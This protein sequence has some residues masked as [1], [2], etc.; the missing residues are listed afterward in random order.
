MQELFI[1]LLKSS[2]LI[3]AFFLS[4][5]FLLRKETFFTSNR[6]FL[7]VGL[8]TSVALP[9]FFIRKIIFVEKPKISIEDLVALSNQSNATSAIQQNVAQPIDWLQMFTTVYILIVLFLF[10]KIIVN[11]ISLFK[12]LNNKQIAKQERFSL[13][14]LQENIAPFSFFNFIVF[15]S[16]LYSQDE[17]E[18]I[19]LHEKVHSQQKH[20]FDVLIAKVFSI[21]FWFNPFVWLY[22][23]AIVQN[24]EYIADSK[25]IQQIEDK[26]VYQKALLK[27][28]THQSCLPITNHFYQS[29]I[30]KRIVMLNKNQSHK[31]NS[32]KYAIVI[33]ALI[34]FVFL[35]Q[36]KIVAQEKSVKNNSKIIETHEGADIT[37]DAKETNKSL[38]TLKNAFKE[39]KITTEISKIKRN[40]NGEITGI[41]IKMKSADGR[42]K[43]LKINQSTPIDKIFIYTNRMGNGLYDFGLRHLSANEIKAIRNKID[44]KRNSVYISKKGDDAYVFNLNDS[45]PE[46]KN[47]NFDIE[48]PELAELAELSELEEL[49]SIAAIGS[50]SNSK[51]VIRKDDDKPIVIVNGKVMAGGENV[52]KE[53]LKKALKEYTYSYSSDDDYKIVIDAENIAKISREAAEDARIQMKKM[54]PEIMAQAKRSMKRAQVEMER[55]RPEME[56]ARKDMERSRPDM[57]KAKVEMQIAKEEMIK[58]KVEMEKMKA[59]M[60]KMKADLKKQKQ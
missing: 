59:E 33:P 10:L 58:A 23:K 45:I 17:L 22:K 24:L 52:S 2:G 31:R 18:S 49:E 13:V 20:S 25:A 39:E 28:V 57:E 51:I 40:S 11:V 34:A 1:Y 47:F 7:L 50:G 60:E 41:S 3:A 37:F 48:I 14:D 32:W 55:A 38:K 43:E 9:L 26:K 30:K 44:T 54:R 4:Y 46:L 6:W 42:K 35:F 5:Y 29:L 16:S 27:V 53:E 8:I 12:I 19:L 15:N 36:I 56:R 21:L